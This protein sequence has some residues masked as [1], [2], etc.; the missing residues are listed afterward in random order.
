MSGVGT[1][2][3]NSSVAS[4]GVINPGNPTGIL[5]LNGSLKPLNTLGKLFLQLLHTM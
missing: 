4:T 2:N 3:F 1:I 5:I